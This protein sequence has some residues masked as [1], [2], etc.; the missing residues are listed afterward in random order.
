MTFCHKKGPPVEWGSLLPFP[1]QDN[2]KIA[3]NALRKGERGLFRGVVN[4]ADLLLC[5]EPSSA[6]GSVSA[7]VTGASYGGKSNLTCSVGSAAHTSVS[8]ANS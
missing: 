3:V 7:M 2:K 1:L 4:F 6:L 5:E 8:G